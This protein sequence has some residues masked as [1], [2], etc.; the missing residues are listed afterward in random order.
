MGSTNSYRYVNTNSVPNSNSSTYSVTRIVNQTIDLGSTNSYRYLNV[1]GWDYDSSAPS[2]GSSTRT[3]KASWNSTGA[4]FYYASWTSASNFRV[5]FVMFTNLNGR[6]HGYIDFSANR[7]YHNVDD[8]HC[9]WGIADASWASSVDT[10]NGC[11]PPGGTI[12]IPANFS[13]A[14]FK[15]IYGGYYI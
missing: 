13:G 15:V 11:L 1:K 9:D 6:S 10:T 12:Y 4:S 14:T 8:S 7:C 5:R 3:M 2:S